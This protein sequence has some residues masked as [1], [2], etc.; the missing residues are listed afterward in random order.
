M[1]VRST[2]TDVRD[3]YQKAG[4]ACETFIKMRVGQTVPMVV[5]TG[6]GS[7]PGTD[8]R[9]ALRAVRDSLT[10]APEGVTTLPYLPE[11][12]ARGP[13]ADMIGR[14][15]GLLVDLPVDVQ[16]QG[17][18]LVDRPGR[19]AERTAS[20]R[21]QDL[22]ELAEAF[23]GWDGPLKLQVTGPWTLAAALWLPLGDRV[24]SDAG[25][26][27]D[28]AVSLAEGIRAHLIEVARLLPRANLTLQIDEPSLPSV[29][30]GRVKSD[31]GFRV[32]PTP[33][34][35]QAEHILGTVVSAA[36][37]AGAATTIHC[38]GD[39]P[40]IDLLRGAGPDAISLDTSTLRT[41]DWDAIATA[42]ESGTTFWAGALSSTRPSAYDRV[43]SALATRW[44]E[45]GLPP[46][47]LAHL[48][49]TPACGLAGSTPA[50][51]TAITRATVETAQAIADEAVR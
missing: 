28:L 38:C 20:L 12:P 2:G 9:E 24:L 42:V 5:A 10:D 32:L 43:S 25:A 40:P 45:L 18:R 1:R 30:L 8:I 3:L 37:G 4:G 7:W 21:R 15:A 29:V 16:P 48:G 26:T 11:L 27:R 33:D 50:D 34:S 14:G 47:S 51:A 13:G 44:H 17:W 39:E 31:S 46:A 41:G 19:D 49:V 35:S 36:K 23:D 22:D 6:I